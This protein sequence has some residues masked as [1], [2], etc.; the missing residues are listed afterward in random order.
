MKVIVSRDELLTEIDTQADT[1]NDDN[2]FEN[3]QFPTA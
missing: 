1:H 3:I 2:R